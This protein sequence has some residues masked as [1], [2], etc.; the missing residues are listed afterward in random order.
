V[1]ASARIFGMKA[2]IVMPVDTPAIKITNTKAYGAEV[3]TYDRV[4]EDRE[5]IARRICGATGAVLVPPF[6]DPSVIAGQGTC[7][8]ELMTQAQAMGLTVDDVLAPASGGGL[9]AGIGLAAQHINPK[10][11]IYAVEPE[12]YDDHRRSLASGKRE[13]NPSNANALCDSLLAAMPGELT[14]SLNSKTLAGVYGVTDDEVRR[15]LGYAFRVLKL[16]AE[17]G[18]AVGL[19]AVLAGRHEARGR[20][21]AIVL[22][23]ANVDPDIYAACL[24]L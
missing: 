7:A 24:K 19:A 5:A 11:R 9:V 8:L 3:V 4:T 13:K 16:V 2:T 20:T 22:S 18:G 17:P 1:A 14:W 6:E 21:V 10:A 23:G 15:A 12:A